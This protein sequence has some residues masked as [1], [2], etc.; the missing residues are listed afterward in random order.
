MDEDSYKVQGMISSSRSLKYNLRR[1]DIEKAT[2]E[3]KNY[4]EVLIAYNTHE[5][6]KGRRERGEGTEGE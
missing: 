1:Q 5:C 2:S 4:Y 3:C 6:F